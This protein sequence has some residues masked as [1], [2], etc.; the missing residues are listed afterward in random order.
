M[1]FRI[2]IGSTKHCSECRYRQCPELSI[3]QEVLPLLE[4]E[5]SRY[6]SNMVEKEPLGASLEFLVVPGLAG[7][8]GVGVGGG[9]C[10]SCAARMRGWTEQ[11]CSFRVSVD[12]R[13][14]AARYSRSVF[15]VVFC[16]SASR[17]RGY[18]LQDSLHAHTRVFR[19]RITSVPVSPAR[20]AATPRPPSVLWSIL[21]LD[22]WGNNAEVVSIYPSTL[23]RQYVYASRR[24][25]SIPRFEQRRSEKKRERREISRG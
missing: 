15:C 5:V 11:R 13:R 16:V 18:R 8:R 6:F 19:S 22:T 12:V 23:R 9:S 14:D 3:D 25:I 4:I 10:A 7:C 21:T 1:R 24:A 2:P 17:E 20:N